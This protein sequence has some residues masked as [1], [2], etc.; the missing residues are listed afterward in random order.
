MLLYPFKGRDCASAQVLKQ[1]KQIQTYSFSYL[2]IIAFIPKRI[3]IPQSVSGRP[4]AL[5]S[6]SSS[7]AEFQVT[8]H[9]LQLCCFLP[10]FCA[11]ANPIPNYVALR[12]SFFT[13]LR[14]FR[15]RFLFCLRCLLFLKTLRFSASLRMASVLSS[16]K[17]YYLSKCF[18]AWRLPRFRL[19]AALRCLVCSAARFRLSASVASAS[20][21]AR[22]NRGWI[23]GALPS[24][25]P[26]GLRSIKELGTKIANIFHMQ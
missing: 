25:W 19:S 5:L 2:A 20:G 14:F 1:S 12:A 6:I 11:C 8:L 10:S 3:F 13:F 9:A 4:S 17:F 21:C 24:A 15:C 23:F 22:C 26:S 16:Q 7:L 18:R